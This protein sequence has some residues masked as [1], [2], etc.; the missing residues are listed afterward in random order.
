[1]SWRVTILP[2]AQR[3]M[4]RL[5]PEVQRRVDRAIAALVEDPRPPG[6]KTL[7]GT[8]NL[9]RVRG[10]DCRIVYVIEDRAVLV[11]VVRV[12]HRR[13]VHW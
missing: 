3:D 4:R 1:M 13:E 8:D 11:C 5:A 2:S 10:G 12:R 7:R 6:V 9:Y